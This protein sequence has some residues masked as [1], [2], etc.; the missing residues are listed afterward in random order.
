MAEA[1]G[2]GLELWVKPAGPPWRGQDAA[3]PRGETGGGQGDMT[4]QHWIRGAGFPQLLRDPKQAQARRGVPVCLDAGL[5]SSPQ[6]QLGQTWLPNEFSIP[7]QEHEALGQ[8]PRW[9]KEK[10]WLRGYFY[11]EEPGVSGEEVQGHRGPFG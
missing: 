6:A 11:R 7:P 8:H 1:M 3:R 10:F 5:T 9:P 2:L 4:A